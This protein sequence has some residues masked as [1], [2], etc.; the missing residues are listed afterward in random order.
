[1]NRRLKDYAHL[2]I[3]MRDEAAI[4]SLLSQ[5]AQHG[6]V[7]EGAIAAEASALDMPGGKASPRNFVLLERG[8]EI[9]RE[10]WPT[11]DPALTDELERRHAR[12]VLSGS[13]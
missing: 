1:M 7:P 3:R 12:R 5:M 10:L 13:A 2:T 8:S 6:L 4:S 11:P 9:G